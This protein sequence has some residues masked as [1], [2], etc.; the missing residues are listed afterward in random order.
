MTRA[1]FMQAHGEA[2]AAGRQPMATN[3]VIVYWEGETYRVDPKYLAPMG[4]TVEELQENIEDLQKELTEAWTRAARAEQALD[5]EKSKV[6][7]PTYPWNTP[8]PPR[9]NG[10]WTT[11]NTRPPWGSHPTWIR[12]L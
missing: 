9:D 2:M 7:L 3:P 6:P 12:Y 8:A 1:E 4:P 11:D 10:P 5:L